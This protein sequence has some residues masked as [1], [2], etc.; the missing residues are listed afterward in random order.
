[1]KLVSIARILIARLPGKPHQ[2]KLLTGA[3]RIPCTLGRHGIVHNKREGDGATPAGCFRLDALLY[4]AD[5]GPRPR[6]L[7]PMRPLRREDGWCDDAASGRY[8]RPARL[9]APMRCERLWRCDQLYDLIL[10]L[11][12]NQRPR[13]RGRGSAV[14]F[15]VARTDGAATEG[16]LAVRAAD[17]RRLLPRLST[18]TRL[19]IR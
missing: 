5:R 6:S 4:R 1:M 19:I 11:D 8:N 2:G 14:F 17:L 3:M 12:H 7:L 18:R 16:C 9:P 15:H 10:L 13:V